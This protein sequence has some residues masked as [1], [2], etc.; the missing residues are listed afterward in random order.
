MLLLFRHVDLFYFISKEG[1]KFSQFITFVINSVKVSLV[2]KENSIILI[3]KTTLVLP[4]LLPALPT[5]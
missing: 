5:S 3:L 2:T 1:P 4:S